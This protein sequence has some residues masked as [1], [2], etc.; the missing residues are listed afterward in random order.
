MV[1][2]SSNHEDFFSCQHSEAVTPR[3][4]IKKLSLM[5]M[6]YSQGNKCAGA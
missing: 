2:S 6:K 3:C 5:I 1:S 4:F